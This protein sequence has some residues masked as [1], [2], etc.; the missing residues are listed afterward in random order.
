MTDTSTAAV[1][2][3]AEDLERGLSVTIEMQECAAVTLR[4]LAA[5]RDALRERLEFDPIFGIDGIETR[6]ASIEIMDAE[7]KKLTA[8][9]DALLAQRNAFKA[10]MKPAPGGE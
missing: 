3:L 8:E 1:E 9:R 10:A 7:I 5:E 6:D 2:R 4:A